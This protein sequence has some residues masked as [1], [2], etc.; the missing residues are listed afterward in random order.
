MARPDRFG[1]RPFEERR[2]NQIGRKQRH[3]LFIHRVGNIEFDTDF[4]AALAQFAK[5]ALGQA[6]EAVRYE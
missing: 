2:Q 3:R 4:M 5:E 1:N 6:V